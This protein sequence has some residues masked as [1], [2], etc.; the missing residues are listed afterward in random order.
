MSK[1]KGDSATTCPHCALVQIKKVSHGSTLHTPAARRG[2]LH[3]D[4][5]GHLI[6]SIQG[7]QYIALFIDEPEWVQF[8]KTKD[9]LLDSI[10]LVQADFNATVHTPTG[11]TPD[12][13]TVRHIH[14]DH[15]GSLESHAFKAFSPHPTKTLSDPTAP[16]PGQV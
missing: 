11:Y 16:A 3:I 5:K 9:D 10:K 4:L 8:L 13:V 7:Y 12:Q 15:E 2:K 14:S 6:A 1:Y